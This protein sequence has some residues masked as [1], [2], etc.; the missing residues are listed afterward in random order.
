MLDAVLSEFAAYLEPGKYRFDVVIGPEDYDRFWSRET[1]GRAVEKNE[2]EGPYLPGYI[3][4]DFSAG[5]CFVIKGFPGIIFNMR[6][7]QEISNAE[8]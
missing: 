4:L 6:V 2:W 7:S 1:F 5:R 8:G 3:V